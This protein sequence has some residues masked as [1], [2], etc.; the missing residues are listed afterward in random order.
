MESRSSTSVDLAHDRIGLNPIVIRAS[1]GNGACIHEEMSQVLLRGN[2]H[3]L[4]GLNNGIIEC[5]NF[6]SKACDAA[7]KVLPAYNVSAI[8]LQTTCQQRANKH[9]FALK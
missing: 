8:S 6:C 7:Q 5:G 1:F 9:F 2:I 3:R 4:A